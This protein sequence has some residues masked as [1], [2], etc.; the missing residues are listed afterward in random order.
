MVVCY[1]ISY[2]HIGNA[3]GNMLPFIVKK[4]IKGLDEFPDGPEP[5]ITW[6]MAQ[7]HRLWCMLSQI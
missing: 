2:F 1:R 5:S 6:L 4:K 3:F 7:F